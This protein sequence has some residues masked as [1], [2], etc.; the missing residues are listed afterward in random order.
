ERVPTGSGDPRQAQA[1]SGD[2]RRAQVGSGD[3]R[4]AQL[5]VAFLLPLRARGRT[6]GVLCLAQ[7]ASGRRLTPAD[8][9]L[10]ED[11][12]GRAPIALDNARLYRDV[13]EAD[14]LKNEFLSMLAHE[15]R[16]PLAPIRNAVHVLRMR[17]TTEPGLQA[18]RDIIDRQVQQLVR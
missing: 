8:K 13:R 3:P 18:V 2:P 12:A 5:H 14:R 1:E 11:L 16:N 6:L 17:G 9:A 15:L 10:G 4:R 7:G